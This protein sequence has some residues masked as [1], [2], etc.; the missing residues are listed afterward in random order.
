M[1]RTYTP[2]SADLLNR[3]RKV[4]LRIKPSD[5]A[6]QQRYGP[7]I[8]KRYM[9]LGRA[10]PRALPRLETLT[11]RVEPMRDYTGANKTEYDAASCHL[12]EGNR[13]LLLDGLTAVGETRHS[14]GC[15]GDL[16]C[17]C[18]LLPFPHMKRLDVKVNTN[19][20]FEFRVEGREIPCFQ[21]FTDRPR[22]D[23]IYTCPKGAAPLSS[24]ASRHPNSDRH[25]SRDIT[26][27]SLAERRLRL[28]YRVPVP[29]AGGPC[30]LG[31]PETWQLGPD[32]YEDWPYDAF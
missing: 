13:L 10:L 8:Q 28:L 32:D 9:A 16:P 11:L 4:I 2:A 3:F 30:C 31:P 17:K 20:K 15:N 7:P 1:H 19:R 5:T 26:R 24:N 23:T 12:F 22:A 27:G 6:F 29:C 25:S 21:W 14:F 18:Q